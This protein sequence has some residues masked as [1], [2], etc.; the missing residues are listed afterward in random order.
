MLLR[1]FD[2]LAVQAEVLIDVL[3]EQL[4][5]QQSRSYCGDM[6]E[7]LPIGHA[8]LHAD[9]DGHCRAAAVP[10]LAVYQQLIQPVR[11]RVKSSTQAIG[12]AWTSDTAHR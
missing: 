10:T 3:Y 8:M 4:I 11:S 12:D 1:H 6:R 5:G 9:R 7:R 2:E